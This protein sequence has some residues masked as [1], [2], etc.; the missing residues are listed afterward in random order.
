MST[1]NGDYG[2]LRLSLSPRFW[3]FREKH[4][5]SA[6]FRSQPTT[7]TGHSALPSTGQ[8]RKWLK[9]RR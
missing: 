5:S 2:T 1:D 7:S 9:V 8:A 4:A 3:G 6:C